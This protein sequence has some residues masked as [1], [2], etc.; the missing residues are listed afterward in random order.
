M[1]I[2]WAGL[3][4]LL[5]GNTLL[6]QPPNEKPTTSIQRAVDVINLD[7]AIDETSWQTAKVETEL[8]QL[9]YIE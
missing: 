6:G 2:V 8:M 3:V 1:R 7:G 9:V 5:T 4:F